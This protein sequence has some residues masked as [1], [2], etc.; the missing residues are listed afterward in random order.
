[1]ARLVFT[2]TKFSGRVYEFALPKTTV[3]RGDHNTL[4]IHDPSVSQAHCEILVYGPEVI[5][6][7]L[8]STNGTFVNGVRLFNQQCQLKPGQTVRFGLV[9]A[10]LELEPPSVSDTAIAETAIFSHVRH[11]HEDPGENLR[12]GPVSMALEPNAE[13]NQPAPPI[14]IPLPAE[15][16]AVNRPQDRPRL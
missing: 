4:A 14:T 11:V 5:V 3:G 13:T 2:D 7:D 16:P 15:Q 6:R 12:A 10:R 1:M 8:G 9:E